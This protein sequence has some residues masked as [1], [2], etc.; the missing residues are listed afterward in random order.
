MF[1]SPG[2]AE[3]RKETEDIYPGKGQVLSD[4]SGNFKFGYSNVSLGIGKSVK[5]FQNLIFKNNK[6][7]I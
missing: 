3:T 2:E 5:T 6:S 4:T 1:D 7:K